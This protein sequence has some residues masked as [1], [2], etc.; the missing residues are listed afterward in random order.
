MSHG[1][2][3]NP[4]SATLAGV[5]D[6]FRKQ[7]LESRFSDR[8]FIDGK[9]CLV[10][11]ANRGLGLAIACE[12]ASRGGRLIMACRSGIPQAGEKVKEKTGSSQVEMMHVDLSD[13]DSIH[14]LCDQLESRKIRIDILVLNAGVTPPKSQQTKQGQDLMFMVNYLSCFILANRLLA[15]GVIPNHTFA[16]T[17]EIGHTPRIVFISSDS[18]QNASAIDYNEFGTYKQYGV[19]KA[20]N[21]YSYFKLVLNT[22][23][24]ELSRRLRNDTDIDVTVNVI[25]PGPVNTDIIRDAPFLL[26]IDRKSV[27]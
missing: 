9:T 10:T 26:R 18:H 14:R 25:C 1:R 2:F 4:V 21:N 19:G 23:A 27:V 22:F 15:T 17:K 3:R 11:G 5:A 7:Q 6:F 24:T 12:L 13:I 8:D 20:I 16:K